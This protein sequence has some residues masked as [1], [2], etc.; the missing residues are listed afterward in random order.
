MDTLTYK[1]KQIPY[2]IGF[3]ALKHF[4][5]EA[6]KPAAKIG[7]GTEGSM[8]DFEILLYHALVAGHK[9]EGKVFEID[10]KEVEFILDE[11]FEEFIGSFEKQEG[12]SKKK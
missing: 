9:A 3:Y 2:R 4:E 10:R 8:N 12:G 11:C 6:K 1:G 5:E 7:Q